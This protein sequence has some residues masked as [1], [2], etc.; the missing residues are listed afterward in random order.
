MIRK[1]PL[2]LVNFYET[3]VY[4]RDVFCWLRYIHFAHSLLS[5]GICIDDQHLL[6]PQKMQTLSHLRFDQFI[7]KNLALP[8]AAYVRKLAASHDMYSLLIGRKS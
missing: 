1:N 3:A 4:T 7:L 5:D 8:Y 6:N 2:E